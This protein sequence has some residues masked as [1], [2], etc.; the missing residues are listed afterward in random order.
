MDVKQAGE[1]LSRLLLA[2]L[3]DLRGGQVKV[4]T[5]DLDNYKGMRVRMEIAGDDKD[6]ILTLI[7]K[8]RADEIKP[9]IEI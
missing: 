6:I 1:A 9:N 5:T 7:T 2:H 3:V 8:E 4:T